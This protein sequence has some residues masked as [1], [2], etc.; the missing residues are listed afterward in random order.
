MLNKL[1]LLFLFLLSVLQMHAQQPFV[2]RGTVKSAEGLALDLVNVSVKDNPG[3]AVTNPEGE[4]VLNINAQWPITLV[5]SRIGYQLQELPLDSM[6]SSKPL[7]VVLI[8]KTETVETVDIRAKRRNKENFTYID[9]KLSASL[10][11][12]SGGGIEGLVKTQMGVS[13]NNELSSQYRVRGGNF[14]ENLVYVNDIEVYRPLLIRAGQQEGLSF[15][16]PEMVSD[17][18]FSAGGFDARYGDK[19]SSVLDIRYKRPTEFGGS[20][21]A[22][23]LGA[24]AHV[25]GTNANGKFTHITG[26]RYKTNKY[27]VSSTDV[28]GDYKPSF[29]D[30]QTY[31]TYRFNDK[32]RLGFLGNIS[33]NQYNFAP[34]DRETSFGTINEAKKLKM[35]FEGQ[36]RD[37]FLTGFGAGV[38]NFSPNPMHN[39]KF[40]VSGYR[41][42]E[43]ENYDILGQYWLQELEG[44]EPQMTDADRIASGI[45]V[46]SYLEHA[47][48]YLFGAITNVALRGAHRLGDNNIE[49][50][51]KYQYERFSDIINEW[52]MRDSADF[53][54]PINPNNWE[55]RDSAD[56]TQNQLEMVYAYNAENDISTNRYTAFVQENR[57][58]ELSNGIL[59]VSA[60][61]RA[62]YWD[63]ND[64][65]L[66]SPRLGVSLIPEWKKD[67]R[68]RFST[69]LY[70]Q[71]PFYK[72]YRMQ[73]GD[74]NYTI[75]A[76]QSI[77]FVGGFDYYFMRGERPFKFSTEL[78][79]KSMKNLIPYRID[80]VRIRYS[81]QNN[82]EGY[83]AGID[84]KLNGEFVKGVESW[85]TL[86]LM[87]TEED[88]SDDSYVDSQ[89]NETIFPG[90]IPR[91]SDQRLNFSL[92]F[93]DY[94]RNNPSFKVNLNF[95]YGT[96]LPF[97]PPRSERYKAINRMPAYRRVDIGFSK[98]ITGTQL[99][100]NKKTGAFKNIWI[101]VEVFNLFDINNTISYF[102]VT[103]VSNRQYAVPNY[104]TSRRLNVKLI[105]RF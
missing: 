18:Q 12:A 84:M 3:G 6:A 43:D 63:F 26:L 75:K 44:E 32:W 91:P 78:Y 7:A 70:Y 34:V 25:E 31:L 5:F 24:H 72:E 60:G 29:F 39:L 85:A 69:G 36:E 66:I 17:V 48:N 73:G 46:G 103:D 28:S 37:E 62:N 57:R 22:S 42:S 38:L 92:M 82:A 47:R 94:F 35:Y 52:E 104:L 50:E 30:V 95:L 105:T 16:N 80:N 93:Q 49:W 99:N 13:S 14:D 65:L 74:I 1:I 45:G 68:F 54:I 11:D 88:L 76:Q 67:F 100:P 8:V 56:F 53:N 64:E 19:M 101:G 81:A 77:H 40:T 15:V 41:T 86:S 89:S 9:S 55:M 98:E 21:S 51:V 71:S 79:Y 61:I 97:G 23:L 27:L 10:P 33:Q 59:D 96:G 20:A 87:S 58:F 102:W 83:A 2:I 4:F 90:Y